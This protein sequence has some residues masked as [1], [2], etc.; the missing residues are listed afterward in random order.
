MTSSIQDPL[1]IGHSLRAGAKG[2]AY[3][4][5]L[6]ASGGSTY[7]FTMVSGTLPPACT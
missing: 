1:T 3:S 5:T 6:A 2:H 4:A 7:H